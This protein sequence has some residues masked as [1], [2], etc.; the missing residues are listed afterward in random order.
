[1]TSTATLLLVFLSLVGGAAADTPPANGSPEPVVTA[2]ATKDYDALVHTLREILDTLQSADDTAEVGGECTNPRAAV[3]NLLF[4]LQEE[5]YNPGRAATCINTSKLG[6]PTLEAPVLAEQLKKV[7]DGRNLWVVMEKIPDAAD[8]KDTQQKHRFELFPANLNGV[9]WE[10]AQDGQW[11]LTTDSLARIPAL[12]RETYP[13]DL[14]NVVQL[15]PD[16][17]QARVLNIALWQVIAL[18]LLLLVALLL[19]R[20]VVSF[21][22]RT[23]SRILQRLDNQAVK[24]AVD[25]SAGP[26]GGLVMAG[27]LSV[28]LP[29]LQLSAKVLKVGYAG[30][31]LLAAI[32]IVWLGFRVVDMISDRFAAKAEKTESKLDDQLVPLVRKTLKTVVAII[33]GIFVLQN[34]DVDVGSLLAGLGLGGL[35]FALAAKDTVANFFGSFM[36][37]IDKPFQVGDAVKIGSDVEGTVEEVGFRTSRV[38][39]YYNSLMTVPNARVTN[40]TIDNFGMRQFRRYKTTLGLTYDTSPAKVQAFCEGVRAIIKATDGMR[41]DYYVVE[42]QG[43]GPSSLDILMNAFVATGDYTTE[44]R[45]RSHLNLQI[46]RLAERLEIGFAFPSQSLYVESMPRESGGAGAGPGDELAGVIDAFGPGGEH[47]TSRQSSITSG[48]DSAPVPLGE[49]DD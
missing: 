5:Q 16:W 18:A 41:K 23:M 9:V 29:I 44:M 45:V 22:T 48:Y 6:D 28:G 31:Q 24:Q 13:W 21:L 34:L 47:A 26:V 25:R 46:L 40:D 15:L 11:L 27:V 35:A 7:L 4:W 12:Y 43:F 1:M 39:T 32:S 33:G 14:N 36:I 10:R 3:H 37:F 17:L 49:N 38:R 20:L 2:E 42:F 8:H 30:V 19:K